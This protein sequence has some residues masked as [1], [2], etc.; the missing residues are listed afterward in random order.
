MNY[1]KRFGVLAV[2]TVAL[3][4]F[5]G[6]SSAS[7][8]T[9]FTSNKVGAT[10][11]ETTL[12]THVFT[13][14][15]SQAKCTSIIFTGSTEALESTS[16]KV[17]PKYESCTIFGLPGHITVNNCRYN[18]TIGTPSG[19]T[20]HM[21]RINAA[22]PC[23]ITMLGKNIFGECH[24]EVT[25]QTINGVTYSNDPNNANAIIMKFS[26][27][28]ISD[29]VTESNGVCPLTKGT[30]TNA[31]YTGESTITASGADISVS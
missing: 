11:E 29:H 3:T 16:Q 25:E 31:T 17:G 27:S 18:F 23:E 13:V 6:V 24:V 20:F 22:Q 12:V 9:K 30:H 1:L 14:T 4:A 5:V 2:A 21:E 15:G 28:G 10:I 19:N 7:A 26:A 8:F